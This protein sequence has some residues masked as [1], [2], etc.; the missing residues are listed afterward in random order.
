MQ[1]A[2]VLRHAGGQHGLSIEGHARTLQ[3]DGQHTAHMQLLYVGGSDG[4]LQQQ[5]TQI[6]PQGLR[7]VFARAQRWALTVDF[8]I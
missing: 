7:L 5:R 1:F 6:D 2:L 3:V 8:K 4:F